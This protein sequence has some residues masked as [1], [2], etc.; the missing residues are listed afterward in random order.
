MIDLNFI[1]V[2]LKRNLITQ[3]DE[4]QRFEIFQIPHDIIKIEKLSPC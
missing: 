3:G 2:M 4:F 1:S